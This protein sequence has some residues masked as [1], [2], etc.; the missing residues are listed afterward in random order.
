[1]GKDNIILIEYNGKQHYKPVEYFGGEESFKVQVIKD[2][3][4]REYCLSKGI[5]LIEIDYKSFANIESI[6][7]RELV[8]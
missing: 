1:M 4:K 8:K 5:R 2:N 3:I 6:L 7:E